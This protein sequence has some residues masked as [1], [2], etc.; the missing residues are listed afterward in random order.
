ML[1][2]CCTEGTS[3]RRFECRCHNESPELVDAVAFSTLFGSPVTVTLFKLG[4]SWSKWIHTR[5]HSRFAAFKAMVVPP[6]AAL[7][8]KLRLLARCI[9]CLA[10]L[11]ERDNM[12]ELMAEVEKAR[13]RGGEGQSQNQKELESE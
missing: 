6:A 2:G 8:A 13:G 5:T 9:C 11:F 3:G 7:L 4:Q 1:M 10:A 12:V